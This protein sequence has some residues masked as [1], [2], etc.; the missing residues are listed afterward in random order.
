MI[1]FAFGGKWAGFGASGLDIR[2]TGAACK[3]LPINELN[4][5]EPTPTPQ[6]L[7]K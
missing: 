7:K 6:R 5:I 1:L 4:A 2:D 3:R